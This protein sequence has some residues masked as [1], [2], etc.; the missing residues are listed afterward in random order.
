MKRMSTKIIS[1]LLITFLVIAGL[2]MSPFGVLEA[3]AEGAPTWVTAALGTDNGSV[4]S[5][6]ESNGEA[7][8]TIASTAQQE[9]MMNVSLAVPEN[10]K[11]TLDLNGHTLKVVSGD[12]VTVENGA[13]LI[14]VSASDGK[15]IGSD[16]E[17]SGSN[18]IN[19]IG[20]GSIEVCEHVTVQGGN[21]DLQGGHGIKSDSGNITVSG[22]VIGGVGASGG[23]YGVYNFEGRIEVSGTAIGGNSTDP[24]YGE[25]GYGVA[26]L[27]GDIIVSGTAK[28]GDGVVG[29]GDGVINSEGRIE[30]SGTAKGGDGLYGGC[31]VIDH[32]GR[33]EISGTAIGGNSNSTDPSYGEAGYGVSSSSGEVFVSG[34]AKGGDGPSG[35]HGVY[36]SKGGTEISGKAIGGK[37][38]NSDGRS[39]VRSKD[40]E[41]LISGTVRGGEAVADTK[42]GGIGVE[43]INGNIT[44]KSDSKVTG[45]NSTSGTGGCGVFSETGI[46]TIEGGIVKGGLGKDG[47]APA[48]QGVV[49]GEPDNP[50]NPDDGQLGNESGGVQSGNTTNRNNNVYTDPMLLYIEKCMGQ[51]RNAKEGDI[52]IIDGR[53][54]GIHS[55][56]LP[57]LKI[58]AENRKATIIMRYRYKGVEFETTI[59]AGAKI[60]LNENI[61][62]Y[63]PLYI[64]SGALGKD[65]KINI[66]AKK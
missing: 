32:Y 17:L 63:G 61:P 40:G 48:T 31:G 1:Y 58:I 27:S 16:D 52:V 11:L 60:A 24:S 8:L 29:G 18:A 33:I 23:G 25:A 43:N 21:G 4:Y 66:I 50:N 30:I 35:G 10:K 57:F 44:I 65:V 59:P 56:S 39:G 41:I 51:I 13:T 34:T 22:T 47:E 14:V 19:A 26:S 3:R 38:T 54:L 15:I 12:A 7:T 37:S 62:W 55:F 46:T 6:V 64:A 49:E 28:G 9:I 5:Y 36:N 45:G 2:G 53:E 42:T 20:T